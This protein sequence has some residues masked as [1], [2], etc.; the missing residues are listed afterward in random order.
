MYNEIGDQGGAH[1]ARLLHQNHVIELGFA[2]SLSI[3]ISL[4][5]EVFYS[6]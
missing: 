5:I 3:I 4:I 2:E 6:G 1:L